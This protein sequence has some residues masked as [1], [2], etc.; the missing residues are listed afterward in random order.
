MDL[1]GRRV[2][3]AER[4]AFAKLLVLVTVELLHFQEDRECMASC[5]FLSKEENRVLDGCLFCMLFFPTTP[6]P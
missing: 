3:T 2:S 5:A 4:E 1:S 6:F